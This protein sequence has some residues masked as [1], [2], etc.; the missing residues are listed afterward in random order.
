VIALTAIQSLNHEG[1]EV[2]EDHKGINHEGTKITETKHLATQL[3]ELE[4]RD[5]R[6]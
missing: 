5:D 4:D 6:D 3:R 2:R 1:H